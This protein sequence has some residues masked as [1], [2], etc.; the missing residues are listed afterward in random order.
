MTQNIS[1]F[2]LS[3]RFSISEV[4]D[5][6]KMTKTNKY[7]FMI[8]HL[9][10]DLPFYYQRRNESV[11]SFCICILRFPLLQRWARQL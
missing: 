6:E 8:S 9:Y 5:L 3:E 1:L 10:F 11:L 4:L 2:G 7:E